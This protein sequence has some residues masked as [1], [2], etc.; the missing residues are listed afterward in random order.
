MY[1]PD[2]ITL[3]SDYFAEIVDFQALMDTEDIELSEFEKAMMQVQ[4]NNYIQTMD[5]QML[6]EHEA[7]FHITASPLDTLEYRRLRLLNLYNN[8]TPLTMITLQMRLNEIVGAGNYKVE[9]DYANCLMTVTI[10]NGMMGIA[11][12]VANFLIVSIPAHIVLNVIQPLE[13]LC[14]TDIIAAGGQGTM[15][16]YTMTTED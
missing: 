11:H 10:W 1:P 7:L 4:L 14:K 6:T 16:I 5:T 12:E 13:A 2:L 3:L 8:V 15:M 9:I